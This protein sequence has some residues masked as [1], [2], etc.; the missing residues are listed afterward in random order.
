MKARPGFKI[1]KT[2]RGFKR[3]TFED[4]YGAPC[5]IQESLDGAFIWLGVS[6]VQHVE[7][8]E[9]CDLPEG[10]K[11]LSRMHLNKNMAAKLV[12]MLQKFIETGEL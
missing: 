12:T 1:H 6:E 3:A 9:K 2:Q 4:S 11:C 10:M 5:S 7:K 8:A